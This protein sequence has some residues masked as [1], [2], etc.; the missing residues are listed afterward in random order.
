F[1]MRLVW[2]TGAWNLMADMALIA[3]VLHAQENLGLGAPAYGLVLAAG[4]VGG[5]A[6]GL[7]GEHVVRRFGAGRTAQIGGVLGVPVFLGIAWAQGP[8]VAAAL[9]AAFQFAGL[10][11]DTVSTAYRQRRIPDGL[12][13]RVHAIYRLVSFTAIPLGMLLSGVLVESAQTIMPR[14]VALTVPFYVASTGM[15]ILNV[16][17]WTSIRRGFDAG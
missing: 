4:A 8:W 9:L 12:R 2:I 17:I 14:D 3:L 10:L 1:L 13:G 16:M 11:W 6:G 7:I 15:L 5:V